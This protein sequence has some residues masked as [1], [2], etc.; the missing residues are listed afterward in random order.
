MEQRILA[1]RFHP[2]DFTCLEKQVA[3][4]HTDDELLGSGRLNRGEERPHRVARR[5]GWLVAA[6]EHASHGDSEAIGVEG[7]EEIITRAHL[8]GPQRVLIVR[9]H[10]HDE[11]KRTW[12]ER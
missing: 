6:R 2:L 8:E 5:T 4:L 12:I 1:Y 7:L 11:R 10:E 9:G 3:T